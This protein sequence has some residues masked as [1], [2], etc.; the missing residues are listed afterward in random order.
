[1]VDEEMERLMRYHGPF[2]DDDPDWNCQARLEE[3]IW[4]YINKKYG[5]NAIKSESTIRTRVSVFLKTKRA[6][7]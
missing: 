1:M 7:K 5:E 4:S 2:S 6:D 3:A